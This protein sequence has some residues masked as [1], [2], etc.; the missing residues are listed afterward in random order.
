MYMKAETWKNEHLARVIVLSIFWFIWL[1]GFSAEAPNIQKNTVT[2]M[3]TT[4]YI[5]VYGDVHIQHIVF[6]NVSWLS[7]HFSV[8]I[9]TLLSTF[10]FFCLFVYLLQCRHAVFCLW[11]HHVTKGGKKPS[12]TAIPGPILLV[13]G[14]SLATDVHVHCISHARGMSDPLFGTKESLKRL[15]KNQWISST[16][17]A[18]NM[19]YIV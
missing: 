13:T 8:P 5:Y 3:Y 6:Y 18:N 11:H 9:P 7:H 16:H 4:F 14:L 15:F 12:I 2:E 1:A 10:F 19:L 17:W